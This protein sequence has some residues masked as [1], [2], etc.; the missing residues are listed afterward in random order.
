MK[1]DNLMEKIFKNGISI[2]TIVLNGRS[3]IEE[4][5]LSVI[6]QENVEY[7]YI[8]IDGGS[9]DGTLEIIAKY[10]KH[11]K[12]L[13]SEPDGGIYQAINKGILLSSYQLIGLI[14]CGDCYTFNA[15]FEVYNFFKKY[16]AD[17]VYGDIEMKDEKENVLFS[18]KLFANHKF[19]MKEMS[20]F[21]PSTFV[22][23]STYLDNGIYD[24][25][26]RIAADYDLFLNLYLKKKLFV[27]VP[28]VLTI[29]RSGGLS[30]TNF[31]LS[32]RENYYI[33]KKR[34]GLISALKF[35]IKRFIHFQYFKTR[36]SL[37]MMLLGKNKVL[38]MK[39]KHFDRLK[40]SII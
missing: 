15:F 33:R 12:F 25:S 16:D 31:F 28:K 5:I 6:Q 14:H 17:V 20:I 22:N 19:L 1:Y 29:F 27:Y 11:I 37:L 38:S 39:K 8:I 40:K 24:E 13:V 26:F 30:S 9:T 34:I 21:H 18:K 7:E 2:I 36:N 3:F 10:I 23:H 32:L 4:T 35:I